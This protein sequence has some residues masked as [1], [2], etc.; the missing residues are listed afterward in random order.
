MKR[1]P[2]EV[3]GAVAHPGG[4]LVRHPE[5]SIGVVRAAARSSGLTLDLIARTPRDPNGAPQHSLTDPGD[6]G[7]QRIGW[8]DSGG[9][10]RRQHMING[11]SGGL[12]GGDTVEHRGLYVLPPLFGEV[13][14]VFEWS[15]IGFPETVVPL[16]LPTREE[17][18]RTERSIWSAP[19]VGVPVEEEFERDLSDR[20]RDRPALEQGVVVAAPM[21]LHGSDDAAVA[22]TRLTDHG[23]Q[24]SLAVLSVARGAVTRGIAPALHG[25]REIGPSTGGAD[26]AVVQ[27]RRAHR[28]WSF[29]GSRSSGVDAFTASTEHALA[30]P[31]SG[32][33]DLLVSWPLAGLDEVRVELTL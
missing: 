11:S 19:R 9:Q 28:V 20:R 16:V 33:L 23:S 15:E 14:F 27:G 21:V 31:S 32:V 12:H 10:V 18:E 29:E 1:E 26:I 4:L 25:L 13:S 30:R 24:L 5:V 2:V 8:V 22:L 6:W 3:L 7:R 17:V